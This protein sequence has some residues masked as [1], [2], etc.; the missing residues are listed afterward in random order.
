STGGRD[1]EEDEEGGFSS[2]DLAYELQREPLLFIEKLKGTSSGTP[3]HVMMT[4]E[5]PRQW[6]IGDDDD[7]S[8]TNGATPPRCATPHS[9]QQQQVA[10]TTRGGGPPSS[11]LA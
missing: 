3:R 11:S 7:S 4:R 6:M 8:F 10:A 9:G 2:Q 1:E 5:T